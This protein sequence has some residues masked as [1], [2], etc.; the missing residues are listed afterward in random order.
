MCGTDIKQQPSLHLLSPGNPSAPRVFPV[1]IANLVGPP[2]FDF[3]I[4]STPRPF[5]SSSSSFSS[6]FPQVLFLSVSMLLRHFLSSVFRLSRENNSIVSVR[7]YRYIFH[8]MKIRSTIVHHAK[9]PP[10]KQMRVIVGK[11]TL[12][13]NNIYCITYCMS[14]QCMYTLIFFQF[15]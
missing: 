8:D 15:S 11:Y 2:N 12:Y 13:Y 4:L 7:R 1:S 6:L 5:L 14:M 9:D 3:E 10:M